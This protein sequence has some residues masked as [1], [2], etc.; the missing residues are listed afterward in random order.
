[1]NGI[2]GFATLLK[3][4]NLSGTEQQEYIRIIEK[5][6]DRLLNIIDD[7]VEHLDTFFSEQR[8]GKMK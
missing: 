7:I 6:G 8:I 5:S 3:E 2:L 1:M 4:A